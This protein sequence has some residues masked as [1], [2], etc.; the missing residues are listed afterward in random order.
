METKQS[1]KQE[2]RKKARYYVLQADVPMEDTLWKPVYHASLD[3]S[4]CLLL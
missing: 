2:P 4:G 1:N 3:G